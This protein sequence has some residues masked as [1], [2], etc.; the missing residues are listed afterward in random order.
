MSACSS[1][2][3][4]SVAL[5]KQS[6]VRK[7]PTPW[8]GSALAWTALGPSATLASSL[9][10]MPSEVAAGPDHSARAARAARLASTRSRASSGSPPTST[11]PD[12]PSTTRKVPR[13]IV[14]DAGRADHAGDAELAGDDR[15]VAGGAAAL[16][17]QRGDRAPGPG[18]RCRWGRG[19][20]RR[21]PTAPTG[22]GTPGSGSPT[23]WATSRRSMS[24][25]SVTRSAISP[26]MLVKM[27][28]NCATAAS[29]AVTSPWPGGR[30]SWPPR[31]RSPLSRARPALAVSTSAAGPVAAS[32]LR[33]KLSATAATA[34]SYAAIAS[35]ASAKSPSPK[36]AIGV[37][38]DLA[39]H[40]QGGSGGDS[41]DD[42]RPAEHGVG[43]GHG[44]TVVETVLDNQQIR[45]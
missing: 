3:G 34:S 25:R 14:G 36:R 21:A 29:T 9:T 40:E 43:C 41:R 18:R 42:G 33:A 1:A 5:R 15:G 31:D 23:R 7:R 16:G 27:V 12:S 4:S 35:S 26:P 24:S 2:D 10:G 19:P 22:V 44:H 13:S 38:R 20:R 39:A 11:S 45:G 30:R 32:A 28:T 6:S 8:T 37:R 17:H